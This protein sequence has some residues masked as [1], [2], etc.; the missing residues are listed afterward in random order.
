DDRYVR[1]MEC[2]VSAVSDLSLAR[3]VGTVQEIVRTAARRLTGAD[4]ATFVLRDGEFCHYVDENAI[5]PLWK[6]RRFPMSICI[7]GW[8]MANKSSVV[9]PDIYVDPRIPAEAYR[10]TFVKSLA[11]VPIRTASPIGAIGN[12]WAAH[13][14]AQTYEVKL[15]QALA[16]STSVALENISV[17]NELESRV[18]ERTA[19]LKAANVELE[20][21]SYSVSHDLRA[22]LRTIRGFTSA[23]S[24]NL[25]E[26]LD[27]RASQL[28]G[29]IDRA[30]AR[31]DG[32]I[33]DLLQLSRV[34]REEL[35]LAHVDLSALAAEVM[36]EFAA[37]DPA[38]HV[39]VDIE[40]NLTAQADPRLMRIALQ[41]LFSNAWKFTSR[42]RQ[43][44][45]VFGRRDAAFFVADNG[46]GFDMAQ[47]DGLFTP[48]KRLH[49]E[50]EFAGTGI[51]LTIVQRVLDRH[52]GELWAHAAVD[53]GATFS[54]TLGRPRTS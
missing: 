38:R 12:Y 1:G 49:T 29:K 23:L 43:P 11:M 27:S 5:A 48:F 17:H 25:G 42:Q 34:S 7:S 15:L 24:D 54:F 33:D 45:I 8:V 10:P 21:F 14:A 46:A 35:T 2:L 19:Q 52:G 20:A 16:D 53:K 13:H 6:G 22:P 44:H 18:S 31:M 32:L 4:G 36:S 40:P 41:N 39:R 47:A 37:T 51:G 26:Q 3:N 30:A 50:R 28:L 9:L